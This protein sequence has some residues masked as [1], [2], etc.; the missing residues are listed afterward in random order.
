MSA[1]TASVK[2]VPHPPSGLPPDPFTTGPEGASRPSLDADMACA[3]CAQVLQIAA[4]RDGETVAWLHLGELPGALVEERPDHVAVPVRR[5]EV[6]VDEICDFCSGPRPT[7]LLPVEEF[8][9]SEHSAATKDWM[10]CDVC[11]RLIRKSR[12]SDL[13]KRSVTAYS[14][15]Y[16]IS[17][18]E[19]E[20][21]NTLKAFHSQVREYQ[22]GPIRRR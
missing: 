17:P 14:A 22:T 7:W 9:V 1:P 8:E 11:A 13:T 10:A 21:V 12:W 6:R 2:A 15:K 16:S 18:T 19:P 5:G 3:V 20:L 4:T